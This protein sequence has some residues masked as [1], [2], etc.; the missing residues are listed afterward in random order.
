MVLGAAQ[1]RFADEKA[2]IDVTR[3]TVLLSSITNDP[4]PINWDSS[5]EAKLTLGDL[6]SAPSETAQFAELAP[7]ASNARNYDIWQK[8]FANWLLRTQKL[9][10]LRSPSLKEF[11]RPGEAERD[12]RVRL[13]QVA[14]EQRDQSAER[15]RVKYASAFTKLDQRIGS[16]QTALERRKD[17]ESE[18]RYEGAMSFGT[19]LLGSFLGRKSVRKTAS[20]A[21]RMRRSLKESHS[22]ENAE[23]RLEVLQKKRAQLE[24][25]FQSETSLLEAKIDPLTENLESISVRPSRADISI[26]LVALV[27]APH[28]QD[29]QRNTTPAWQ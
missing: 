1:I 24:A 6:K 29:S 14:R 27:W 15:L 25:Q 19:S 17:R 3:D 22:K 13:Q 28:W 18:R 26:K 8:D 21:G 23:E 5:T 2:R 11:S 7:P 16:A 4:I 10:L 9:D 20:A 12:F